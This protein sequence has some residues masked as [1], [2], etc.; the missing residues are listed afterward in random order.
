MHVVEVVAHLVGVAA[1]VLVE[2]L[3][4]LEARTRR[5]DIVV[6][7]STLIAFYDKR[8]PADVVS[9]RHFDTWWKRARQQQPD[10]LTFDPSM[11]LHEGAADVSAGGDAPP[12]VDPEQ[13][14]LQ[15]L[16]TQ[17]GARPIET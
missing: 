10:L 4:E 6:D 13:A 15:L 5:R 11:L 8:I 14:A 16:R 17:L 1:H 12:P 7:D 9:G 2:R 3:G